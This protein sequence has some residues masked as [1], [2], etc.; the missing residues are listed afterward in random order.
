MKTLFFVFGIVA[1]SGIGLLI[2]ET[3]TDYDHSADFKA[4]KSYSWINADGGNSLWSD[5]I[6]RAVDQQLASKGL[7]RQDSGADVA[8]AAIG[9][10]RREQTYTTFYN[11]IGGGW[12]WRGF[13]MPQ[14]ATT[15]VQE[16]P[17]GT[18]T[19]DMFDGRSKKLVWRGIAIKTLSGKPE[20]NTK[21]LEDAVEDLFKKFP[22]KGES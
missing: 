15:T 4:Y 3:K 22:P 1:L 5:R 6:R 18:L 8:V 2:A 13:N 11:G 20:K 17:V 7:T 12:F 21:K 14:T 10:T 19:V 9:R 16:T